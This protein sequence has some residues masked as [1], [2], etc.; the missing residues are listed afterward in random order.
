[1]REAF[2]APFELGHCWR[3]ETG[4]GPFGGGGDCFELPRSRRLADW[5]LQTCLGVV[6]GT[7]VA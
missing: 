7:G 3:R 1:M 2:Q 6:N 4:L 5:G